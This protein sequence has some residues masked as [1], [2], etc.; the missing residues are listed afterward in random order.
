MRFGVTERIVSVCEVGEGWGG[1]AD[2]KH[3][4]LKMFLI[5]VND[6]LFELGFL[7]SD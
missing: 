4:M 5:T 7:N 6:F 1:E 3:A 2:N